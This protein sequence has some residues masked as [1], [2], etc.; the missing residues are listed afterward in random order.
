MDRYASFKK[1]IQQYLQYI[2]MRQSSGHFSSQT[3]P[4]IF[5]DHIEDAERNTVVSSALHEVITPDMF[6]KF[7]SQTHD[8]AIIEP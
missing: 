5:I 2:F 6:W 3:F 1:Q 4:R 8:G 7:R